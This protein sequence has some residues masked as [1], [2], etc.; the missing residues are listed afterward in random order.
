MSCHSNTKIEQDFY[1]DREV[2]SKLPFINLKALFISGKTSL[3]KPVS[4]LCTR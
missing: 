3:I 2:L 4:T 1:E